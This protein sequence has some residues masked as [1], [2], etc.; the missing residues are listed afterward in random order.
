MA[1]PPG[2]SEQLQHVETVCKD[3]R[4]LRVEPLQNF[5]EALQLSAVCASVEITCSPALYL[6]GFSCF[7]GFILSLSFGLSCLNFCWTF[8]ASSLQ[9]LQFILSFL[10]FHYL[11]VWLLSP[12][13]PVFNRT[14]KQQHPTIPCHLFKLTRGALLQT[15]AVEYILFRLIPSN[16]TNAGEMNQAMNQTLI[17]YSFQDDGKQFCVFLCC[18]HKSKHVPWQAAVSQ[19]QCSN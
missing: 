3:V 2:D 12:F 1:L 8:H 14:V 7:F 15:L 5:V 10:C 18:C 17:S 11:L 16:A 4:R 6:A 13:Q 19:V 9:Y